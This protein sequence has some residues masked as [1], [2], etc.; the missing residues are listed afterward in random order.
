MAQDLKDQLASLKIDRSADPEAEG[1]RGKK[2]LWILFPL[3][4]ASSVGGFFFWPRAIP[5][6]SAVA[7]EAAASSGP[8]SVLNASGYVTARRQATV[9]SKVTGKVAEVLVE[10]GMKVEEG[11]VLARLDN[12][13]ATLE[14]EL[15]LAQL[16]AA[17]KA[18]AE[19]ESNLNLAKKD[20]ERNQQLTAGG[21]S[22]QSALDTAEAQAESLAARLARQ[23]GDVEVARSNAAILRQL[24]IALAMIVVMLLRPRGL[25][26]SPEHGK[27]LEHKTS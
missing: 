1:G 26:P 23:K 11:Q 14:L 8:A 7:I 21:V 19:T 6:R 4:A 22:S 27:S 2:W 13:Q 10:E 20:L 5:V 25:W 18:L 9:S 15:A 16:G 17:Q 3:I 24:L 12:R